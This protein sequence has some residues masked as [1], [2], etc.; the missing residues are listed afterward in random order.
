MSEARDNAER[1]AQFW[2]QAH[3]DG[4]GADSLLEHAVV[5]GYVSLRAFGST[6]GH[7]D[8]AIGE[9]RAR[10]Q[11]GARI[12]SVGCGSAAK[13]RVIA[14][15]LPDRTM[16]GVDIATETL[17]RAREQAAA[18][19]LTNLELSHGD[20]NALDLEAD[21]VDMILGLG[22]IHHI[23]KLEE[24]WVQCRRALRPGGCMLA[25]EY[26]G[27]SRFQW[28]DAQIEHGNR[29]LRE[30]VPVEHQV[31]HREVVRVP[32]EKVVAIDPSE[33]VR[34]GEIVAT[35]RDSELTIQDYHGCGCSLL[36]PVLM[37]QAHTFDPQN[38]E[39]NHVLFTLFR[40]EARLI[41]EGVLGDNYAMFVA[42]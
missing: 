13:E 2:D 1:T 33:A 37:K 22:A 21:S 16:I 5:Q 42:G 39:H 23:D 27:P 20:F 31:H 18:E 34:S 12:L 8:A 29:A 4:G 24:F 17:A 36:Q 25:Q 41:E 40:D 11:P 19:G 30:T 10:T 6:M 32:V 15:A 3:A 28:S 38:W 35:C 7:L 14:A 26:V 9:I